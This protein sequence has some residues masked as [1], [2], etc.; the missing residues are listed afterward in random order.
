M[1]A[2]ERGDREGLRRVYDEY[3]KLIFAVVYDTI[4]QREEAEDIT[5]EFFIKLYKI[6][7]AYRPGN[8]HKRW[9]VTIAKNMAVDRVRKLDRELLAP[10]PLSSDAGQAEGDVRYDD[11][12]GM[13]ADNEQTEGDV[14]Y[15]DAAVTNEIA[16]DNAQTDSDEAVPL[17]SGARLTV[18]ETETAEGGFI[19]TVTVTEIPE[20][21]YGIQAGDEIRIICD[22]SLET[23]TDISCDIAAFDEEL[24]AYVVINKYFP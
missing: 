4:G 16:A 24:N 7:G 9:L 11:A 23:G 2:I 19:C 18:Q 15:D 3:L 13:E 17:V 12:A 10:E 5:S 22:T 8:G 14:S 21:N 6:A 1:S 20:N